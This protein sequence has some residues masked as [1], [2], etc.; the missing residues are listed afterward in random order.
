MRN[1]VAL[2]AELLA[3]P[4]GSNSVQVRLW[5]GERTADPQGVFLIVADV[6]DDRA[7]G[8]VQVTQIQAID[9]TG[10]LGICLRPQVQG[11][12]V[13]S[14]AILLLKTY[15]QQV[16]GLRKLGLRVRADNAR[17]I[18]CYER[19]GFTRCGLLRAHVRQGGVFHDLVLMEQFL[20]ELPKPCES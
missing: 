1:D 12:R 2:Q 19:S 5:L 13:G 8:Y 17:A 6:A 15:M 20:D 11:Q 16:W 9:Q 10:D 4:R 14:R 3:R 7:L 18:G